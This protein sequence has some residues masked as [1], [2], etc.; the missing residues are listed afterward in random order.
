[1]TDSSLQFCFMSAPRGE[2][3][4]RRIVK[5]TRGLLLEGGLDAFNVEAVAAASGAARTTI[6]RHWPQPHDLLVETLLSM[7]GELPVPD[8]GSLASDLEAAFIASRQIFEDVAARR[9]L[10][11][12][13]RAAA[14]DFDLEQILELAIRERREPVQVIL[15]RAIARGEI[16]PDI[17]LGVAM[18]LIE[19]P[20][21][22]ATVLQRRRTSDE[23][24]SRMVARVLKALS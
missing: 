8:T 5:A 15:Q 11:D 10:L 18:H 23:M 24:I 2:A 6:Y 20:L 4:R 7:G 16:D 13:T 12:I 14:E 19:G 1:M 17:D 21:L 22:S 9:L 3:A